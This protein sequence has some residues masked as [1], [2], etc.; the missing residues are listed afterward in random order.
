MREFVAKSLLKSASPYQ[1]LKGINAL[2]SKRRY[3]DAESYK[4][5]LKVATSLLGED[6]LLKTFADTAKLESV[7]HAQNFLSKEASEALNKEDVLTFL[8]HPFS[9]GFTSFIKRAEYKINAHL[10]NNRPK[11]RKEANINRLVDNT[12]TSMQQTQMAP[13][14]APGPMPPSAAPVATVPNPALP[15]PAPAVQPQQ[16]PVGM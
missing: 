2:F 14:V 16:P 15:M 9:D 4:G 6:F 1:T 5:F 12:R 8:Q 7:R 10:L 11:L 13:S 3:S